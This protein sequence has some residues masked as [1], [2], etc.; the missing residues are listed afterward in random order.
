MMLRDAVAAHLHRWVEQ[1]DGSAG[2][3]MLGWRVE[4]KGTI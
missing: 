1:T 3:R 2:C 4:Q